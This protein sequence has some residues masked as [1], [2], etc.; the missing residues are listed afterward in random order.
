MDIRIIVPAQNLFFLAR[1]RPHGPAHVAAGVLAADH[2]A[3][4]AGGIGGD[5]GV[6]VFGDGENLLAGVT[7]VGDEGEMQPLVFG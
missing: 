2:E 3:D 1:P 6:G 5:G 7:E 4:L